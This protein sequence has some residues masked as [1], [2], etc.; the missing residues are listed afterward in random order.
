MRQCLTTC[1]SGTILLSHP[2]AI[3]PVPSWCGKW[4]CHSCGPRKARR[5]RARIAQTH[6][7]RF[8]TLT[9]RADPSRSAQ[10][11]L[12]LANHAWSILWRRFRRRFPSSQLGY[13]KIVEL[14]RAGTPHL[15]ILVECPFVPQRWIA[16]QWRELTGSFIVD[17]RAIKSRRMM[18]NYLT[19]YLTKALDVPAGH[20]KWSASAHWVPP[21][22]KA[23]LAAGEIAPH[24]SFVRSDLENVVASYVAA[25]WRESNGWYISPELSV[26][27]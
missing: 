2:S 5:L 13:A 7:T 23:E 10:E 22:P 24:G 1:P 15:H 25:G 20:R 4:N 16:A 26:P 6:P 11:L 17:I 27:L 3:R 14:T 9:L 8:L 19:S 12:A 21:A 18:A